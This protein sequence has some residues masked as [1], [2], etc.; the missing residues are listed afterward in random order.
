M[1][2]RI[3]LR[4]DCPD[5]AAVAG[6]RAIGVCSVIAMLLGRL[7]WN[8]IL[9]GFS[10]K[11]VARGQASISLGCL[12]QN[13]RM[14]IPTVKILEGLPLAPESPHYRRNT[15]HFCSIKTSI[16]ALSC[17]GPERIPAWG[18]ASPR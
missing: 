3:G 16:R 8:R 11:V 10:P 5:G 13:P 14:V 2:V 15:A 17:S 4:G 9:L 7:A 1:G 18:S 12:I 6:G